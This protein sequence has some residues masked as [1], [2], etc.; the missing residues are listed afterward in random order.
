[1][2]PAEIRFE[3]WLRPLS[4]VEPWESNGRKTLHW[5]GLTDGFYRITVGGNELFEHHAALYEALGWQTPSTP[6]GFEHAANYPVARL[7]Q[8]L[9]GIASTVESD[10]VPEGVA[11]FLAT[12]DA[13]RAWTSLCE[14]EV[15]P[16]ILETATAWLDA[17]TLDSGHL[18]AGP[19]LHFWRSHAGV[20]AWCDNRRRTIDGH[21]AWAHDELHA[22]VSPDQFRDAVF[23]FRYAFLET[24]EARIREIEVS[25]TREDV[26][27][28][29]TSLRAEH[30]R[31]SEFP[32]PSTITPT[33]WAPVT[34]ALG[35]LQR[36]RDS[37]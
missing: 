23:S 3:F 34:A 30:A 37:A 19:H 33:D 10:P 5:Y 28:D 31:A 27:I 8:D 18:R 2:P 20:H 12:P 4:E 1:M 21:P 14:C 35:T 9:G 11:R 17:R 36:T 15:E 32:N 13:R 16:E 22:L 6:A 25:W 24:M 29:L 26:E 7:F